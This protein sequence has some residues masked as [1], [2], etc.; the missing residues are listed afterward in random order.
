MLQLCAGNG[1]IGK[2]RTARIALSADRHEIP[3]PEIVVTRTG[4]TEN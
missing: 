4:R 2:A 1:P 3:F